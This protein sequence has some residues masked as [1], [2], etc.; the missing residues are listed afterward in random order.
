M[1]FYPHPI[2]DNEASDFNVLFT[3]RLPPNPMP[4]LTVIGNSLVPRPS[5]SAK[6]GKQKRA[7]IEITDETADINYQKAYVQPGVVTLSNPISD[8]YTNFLEV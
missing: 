5:R 6:A 8:Q 3:F 4:D 1:V 7:K 2:S